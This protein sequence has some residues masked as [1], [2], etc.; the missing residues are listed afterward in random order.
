MP[1]RQKP[2]CS[3]FVLVILS[4]LIMITISSLFFWTGG[5]GGQRNASLLWM[6]P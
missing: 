3:C 2:L 1:F 6:L 4:M 5:R